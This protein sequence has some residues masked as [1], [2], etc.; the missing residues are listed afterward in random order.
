VRAPA[1]NRHGSVAFFVQDFRR[2]EFFPSLPP[3]TGSGIHLFTDAGL[4]QL[5]ARGQAAPGTSNQ[6]LTLF[7]PPALNN[8]NEVAF[9]SVYNL[10]RI[11]FEP[12]FQFIGG[13]FQHAS[14]RLNAV[15]LDG[16]PAPGT[17]SGLFSDFGTPA[18]F[19]IPALF[20]F[21]LGQRHRDA[22]R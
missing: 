10:R 8:R 1:I 12:G 9:H 13:I 11:S 17:D 20:P 4:R 21:D 7:G 14:G 22:F 5:A 6:W 16:Q 18:F 3:P 2:I 15:A 19:E